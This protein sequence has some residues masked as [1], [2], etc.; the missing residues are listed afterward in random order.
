[1]WK[2]SLYKREK[3]E[4]VGKAFYQQGGSIGTGRTEIFTVLSSLSCGKFSERTSIR[5][6]DRGII[7]ICQIYLC[8]FRCLEREYSTVAVGGNILSLVV[9]LG[10]IPHQSSHEPCQRVSVWM[11]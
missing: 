3:C 9:V 10:P 11:A 4:W 6:I 1:M 7:I 8:L 2:S 5:A